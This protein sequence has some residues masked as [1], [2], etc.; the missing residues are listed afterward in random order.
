M[1]ELRQNKKFIADLENFKRNPA[2]IKKNAKCLK[3]L[4]ANALL[5]GLEH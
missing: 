5:P 4:E 3:S 2:L 1:P